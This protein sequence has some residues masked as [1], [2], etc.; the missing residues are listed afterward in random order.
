MLRG[1]DCAIV[2]ALMGE[3]SRGWR[4]L[5]HRQPSTPPHCYQQDSSAD[6]M[7]DF[8][9]FSL[10]DGAGRAETVRAITVR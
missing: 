1:A 10:T 6:Q 3:R 9:V 2:K 7:A 8:L 4:P 5:R